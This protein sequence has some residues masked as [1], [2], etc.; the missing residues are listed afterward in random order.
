VVQYTYDGWGN[1]RTTVID[2]ES[3]QIADALINL[4]IKKKEKEKIKKLV[5]RPV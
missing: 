3:K 1:C 5:R 4:G 2:E